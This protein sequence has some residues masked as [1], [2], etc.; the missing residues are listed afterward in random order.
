MLLKGRLLRYADVIG[1]GCEAQGWGWI[2]SVMLRRP[3]AKLL[4]GKLL[5][6]SL[7]LKMILLVNGLPIIRLRLK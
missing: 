7:R 2:L 1:P 6:Y 5:K 4:R 3:S